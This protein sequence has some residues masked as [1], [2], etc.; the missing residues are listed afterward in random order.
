M[1]PAFCGVVTHHSTPVLAFSAAMAAE[2]GRV[3]PSDSVVEAG[4]TGAERDRVRWSVAALLSLVPPEVA[5]AMP[6]AAAAAT[7]PPAAPHP[8][9]LRRSTRGPSLPVSAPETLGR[10]S[11]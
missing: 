11:G 1:S 4:L 6:R 8:M 2:V 7:T 9:N 5:S 10:L 3:T